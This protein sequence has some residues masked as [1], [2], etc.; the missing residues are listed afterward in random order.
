M[1]RI[2]W[3]LTYDCI[4]I[5]V[6]ILHGRNILP[7]FLISTHVCMSGMLTCHYRCTR[8]RTHRATSIGLR[9]AHSLLSHTVNIRCIDI[10]L[11]IASQIAI[12]HIVA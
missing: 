8:R 11:A 1:S 2:I 6:A 10:F 7:I 5:V 3:F 4:F 9:K 12:S